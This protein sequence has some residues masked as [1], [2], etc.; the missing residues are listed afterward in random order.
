MTLTEVMV[1][2]VVLAIG[3]Q[4]SVQG[5]SRTASV[6]AAAAALDDQLERLDHR[7]LASRRLLAMAPSLESSCRFDRDALADQLDR[8]PPDPA[9]IQHLVEDP[10]AQGIWL[11]LNLVDPNL[12]LP[13]E[14][15]L[16]LTPAGLGLCAGE[17]KP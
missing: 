3:S 6:T 9:L 15:R 2:A 11:R 5:W 4:V 17:A 13:L 16:L 10:V 1:S 7:L 14:R 12:D 8:L